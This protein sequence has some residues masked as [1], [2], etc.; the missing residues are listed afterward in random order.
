MSRAQRGNNKM[1]INGIEYVCPSCH[2]GRLV[3]NGKSAY[4]L[5][6][7]KCKDCKKYSNS[8]T[9][10]KVA[11]AEIVEE[12]V[13]LAKQKQ[14]QQD[15]NRIANKSFRESA[16][17]ENALTEYNK[18]L[19]ELL[20]KQNLSKLTVRHEKES[21]C[22]GVVHITDVHF[23]ELVNLAHNKYDFKIASRR[24]WLLI[25]RAKEYFRMK[26]INKVLLALTGDLMNSD[27]R[28]DEMLAMATNRSKATFL[29]VDILQQAILDLNRDFNVTVAAICGNEGRVNQELG[30]QDLVASDNYDYT[31][32]HT[33]RKVFEG[34]EGVQFDPM[35][36]PLEVV[37]E[38]ATQNILLVHGHALKQGAL[39]RAVAEK[40]AQWMANH[41]I[42]I[43][44]VIFGH[45]HEAFVSDQFA[46]GG[47]PCG[48][49][50]FSSSALNLTGRASQNFYVF[51]E[52]GN[53]D[54]MKVDLQNIE[55]IK[56][57][58]FK[59]ALE[60]YNPKSADKA[61]HTET[62]FKVVI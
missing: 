10:V 32:Y 55:G 13:R 16:R 58:D 12:N 14:A 62:V 11:D 28:R 44:Y 48:D 18:E 39:S 23:N 29:A 53:R 19:I 51:Y 9:V 42:Q 49:N 57:Y 1:I 43:D 56:G 59:K 60:A 3:K 50:A 38:I 47:S 37:I 34:A 24:I 30:W 17:V 25:Q 22:A 21:K 15:R 36:N 46:R 2:G 26:G 4:G 35:Q 54:G 27:R 52:N 5:Q 41:S 6:E 45:I 8:N 61:K 33:L 40:K 20:K 7:Y 31:I